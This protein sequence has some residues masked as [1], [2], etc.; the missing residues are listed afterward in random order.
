[1]SQGD[2]LHKDQVEE[3]VCFLFILFVMSAELTTYTYDEM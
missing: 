2:C 1:M 3:C